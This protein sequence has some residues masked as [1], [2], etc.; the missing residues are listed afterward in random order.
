[1]VAKG[2]NFPNVELVGIVLAD[3]GINIPDF[4]V[5][6]RTFGLITQVAGR[7]GRFSSNG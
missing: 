6:E 1:M 3:S 7:A 2:F 5:Q 4:R